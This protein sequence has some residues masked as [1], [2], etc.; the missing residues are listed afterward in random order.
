MIKSI[1]REEWALMTMFKLYLGLINTPD[2]Q[3]STMKNEEV[4]LSI[5]CNVSI[6]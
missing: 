1:L 6:I 2:G 3:S 4:Q 5:H